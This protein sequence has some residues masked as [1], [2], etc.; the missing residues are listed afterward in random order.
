M[1]QDHERQ[2]VLAEL[3]R[4]LVDTLAQIE[5][6][7]GRAEDLARDLNLAGMSWATLGLMLGITRQAARQRFG[8]AVEAWKR[9]H[10]SVM[11]WQLEEDD[12]PFQQAM[13]DVLDGAGS[14]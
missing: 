13:R 6:L 9:E 14:W 7:R 12:D 1:P 4:E 8:P 3:P 2:A 11:P 5:A 10:G